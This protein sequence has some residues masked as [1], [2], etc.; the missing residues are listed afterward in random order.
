M[1]KLLT[2]GRCIF[3]LGMLL[4]GSLQ[5]ISKT[6]LIA[7]PVL[8]AWLAAPPQG[9]AW[10][11]ASGALLALTGIIVLVGRNAGVAA[12]CTG[13]VIFCCSALVCGIPQMAGKSFEDI[14]WQLNTWKAVAMTGGAWIVAASYYREKRS[15]ETGFYRS[16]VNT[17]AVFLA[18]FLLVGGA[19]H[20]KFNAFVQQLI[21]AYV[22]WHVFWSYFTAAALLAGGLGLLLKPTRGIA[23]FWSGVMVLLFFLLLH[24]P[25]TVSGR[26]D[27]RE[28]MGLFESFS[29]SGMLFVLAALERRRARA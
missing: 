15:A 10:A 8:P 1:P 25:R 16:L 23:A 28:W 6:Y 21:P 27:L 26:Q 11:Y 29:T 20:I 18:L 13:L 14:V 12:F 24:I 5:F 22:P 17:G 4:L 7:R 3:G 19:S 9:P 2:I